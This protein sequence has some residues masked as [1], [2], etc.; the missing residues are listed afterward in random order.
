MKSSAGLKFL[1]LLIMK[2]AQATFT[3]VD[4][5]FT[6]RLVHLCSVRSRTR[7]SVGRRIYQ[8]KASS[9]PC[10][11][12][13]RRNGRCWS[14]AVRH[15]SPAQSVTRMRIEN[16]ESLSGSIRPGVIGGNRPKGSN[17]Q[18]H[19][20]ECKKDSSNLFSWEVRDRISKD[21][22]SFSRMLGQTK[23]SKADDVDSAQKGSGGH[24]HSIDGILSK[25]RAESNF[26]FYNLYA[27]SLL[28][29]AK[30]MNKLMEKYPIFLNPFLAES[31]C[32]TNIISI[33]HLNV[34]LFIPILLSPRFNCQ[35]SYCKLWSAGLFAH[36]KDNPLIL[37]YLPRSS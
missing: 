13:D 4:D 10:P 23:L 11:A 18:E 8:R 21:N 19:R 17:D 29:S 34:R 30:S 27:V 9:Q 20:D 31:R 1:V 22:S 16:P 26:L 12:K 24:K 28:V 14:P 3:T 7:E 5:G 32:D 25:K 35:Y 2:K 33:H 6:D 36:P 15:Q 37:L